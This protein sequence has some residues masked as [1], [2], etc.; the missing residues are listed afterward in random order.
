M[1]RERTDLL[2]T[3]VRG[4]EV[5]V[6]RLEEQLRKSGKWKYKRNRRSRRGSL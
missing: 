2:V 4:L 1:S 6:V 5:R 3:R